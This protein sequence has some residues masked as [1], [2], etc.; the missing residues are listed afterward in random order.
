ML[1]DLNLLFKC[2]VIV[3]QVAYEWA[4]GAPFAHIM[5]LTSLHV[6]CM[7]TEKCLFTVTSS[8]VALLEANGQTLLCVLH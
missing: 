8:C 3:S 7:A 6:R 4:R 1:F 2:G 5:R